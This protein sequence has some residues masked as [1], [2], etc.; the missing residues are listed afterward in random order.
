VDLIQRATLLNY[1]NYRYLKVLGLLVVIATAAYVAID[2]VGGEPCGGTWLGYVL[3]VISLLI[4]FLLTWYG[5]TKRQT[6]KNQ[7]RRLYQMSDRR[8]RENET[9][10]SVRKR[11]ERRHHQAKQS[12]HYGGTLQGWLSAHIYLG[13]SLI[14]LASLHAGFQYGWNVHTLSYVLMLL[15]IAS[16]FF[17][18]YAYLNY[19]RQMTQNMGQ[20]TLDGLIDKISE[21][22]ELA[23]N[24]ALGLPDDVNQLVFRA[25]TETRL[26]GNFFQQV[27]GK[28]RH[29][30]TEFASQ[31]V[32]KLGQTYTMGS[33]PKLMRDLYLVLL[34][35]EKL[36]LRVRNEIKLKARLQCWLYLHVPLA[37]AMF[38]ALT[39]HIVAIFFYW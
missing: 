27:N 1:A 15:V 32:L 38:A 26:G 23:R 22:D 4:V 19:P 14:V 9:A 2:P 13:T 29:C 20:D 12:W 35:K 37:I 36:V 28:Q 33:Q 6:P 24:R 8:K 25:R 5:V 7:D 34:H 3:G 17:G 31:E 11:A 10:L 21:L 16:G 39:A 18:T 30:P